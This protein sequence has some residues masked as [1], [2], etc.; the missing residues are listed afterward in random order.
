MLVSVALV[1]IT[2]WGVH[3]LF[4]SMKPCWCP[5]AMLLYWSEWPALAPKPMLMTAVSQGCLWEPCLGSQSC[6][7]WGLFLRSTVLS[8]TVWQ[9]MVHA[10]TDYKVQ[11]SYFCSDMGDWRWKASVTTLI[12]LHPTPQQP[13]QETMEVLKSVVRVLKCSS[14]Q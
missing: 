13:K 9:P 10:A 11:G 12:S 7:S 8:G 2:P 1:T 5:W 3:D 4:L 6:C 14:P